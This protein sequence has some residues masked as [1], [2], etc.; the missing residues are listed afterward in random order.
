M[1][2]DAI[3][4]FVEQA[5]AV[6]CNEAKNA[7]RKVEMTLCLSTCVQ[8]TEWCRYRCI[9]PSAAATPD[10]GGCEQLVK[11]LGLDVKMGKTMVLYRVETV[12]VVLSRPCRFAFVMLDLELSLMR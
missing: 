10:K 12:P 5:M 11:S 4:L 7:C 9:S 2:S 6:L 3:H 1:Y 8:S